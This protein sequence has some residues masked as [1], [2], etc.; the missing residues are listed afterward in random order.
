M[1]QQKF[2]ALKSFGQIFL[3]V[4]LITLVPSNQLKRQVRQY[5]NRPT[6]RKKQ[7]YP[8]V[9]SVSKE[10]NGS[11][12]RS[13]VIV[14]H[15]FWPIALAKK[16][17]SIIRAPPLLLITIYGNFVQCNKSTVS[18]NFSPITLPKDPR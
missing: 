15:W 17:L 10:I 4:S 2:A 14:C 13:T 16:A 5:S 3:I 11:W 6:C 1:L 18:E 9:G 12:H 7:K 8:K